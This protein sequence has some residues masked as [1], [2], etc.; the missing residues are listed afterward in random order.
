MSLFYLFS[1]SNELEGK[2][3]ISTRTASSVFGLLADA[4]VLCSGII[5]IMQCM[6]LF[7]V[8]GFYKDVS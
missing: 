5:F 3:A 7:R 2:A 4:G 8:L 1:R 6:M